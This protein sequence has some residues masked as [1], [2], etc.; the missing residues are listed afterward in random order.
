MAQ[1][2]IALV[3]DFNPDVLAHRAINQ[4]FAL[5]TRS[6]PDSV[7]PRWISTDKIEP[8][9]QVGF[10]EVSG[11][12]CTPASPYRH[13]EG[14]LWAI[15]FARTR[16]VPFLGTCGGYQHA[17]L[18]YARNV[19]GIAQ[20]GHAELDPAAPLKLLDRMQ[21]SL[22]EKTQSINIT[23]PTFQRLY[24]SDSGVEGFH[25]SYGLNP[26]CD[27]LF[28]GTPL[29]IVARSSDGHA[30]AFHLQGHPFFIGTAFQPER[31]AL[32]GSIHP[33]IQSFFNFAR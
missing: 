14:A 8:G 17:L 23:T 1:T 6:N 4:C 5:A 22:I 33:L 2:C 30:R 12:W 28:A 31:R 32:A 7:L 29:E 26:A 25:C 11:I 15:Q 24:G 13:T 18:E 9:S 16:S 3:G 20:A 27:Q 19:L 21:C 10:E